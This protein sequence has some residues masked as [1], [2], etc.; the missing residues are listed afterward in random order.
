[1]RA[2]VPVDDGDLRDSIEVTPPG[3]VTPPYA[4]GGGKR[5]AGENQALVTVGN[6]SVRTGH[7][8]EF[9]TTHHEAQPFLRPAERLT[10]D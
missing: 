1:M 5:I 4:A 6:E 7:L 2:L 10:R 9:G 3:A 8:Q